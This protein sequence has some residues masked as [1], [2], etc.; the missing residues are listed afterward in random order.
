M[1]GSPQPPAPLNIAVVASG[2]TWIR[3]VAD[4]A[5]AY[6]GFLEAGDRQTWQAKRSLTVRVG[7]AGV[8]N[9]TVNGKPMG[10]LGGSGQVYEH[11]FSSG[12][13]SP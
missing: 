8:V 13:P 11:T 7:N 1:P 6:E 2:H 4:G 5:T 12:A 10:P 9:I 3:T